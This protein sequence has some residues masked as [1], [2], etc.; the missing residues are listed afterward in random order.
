VQLNLIEH[1]VRNFVARGRYLN[2]SVEG[3]SARAAML[4]PTPTREDAATTLFDGLFLVGLNHHTAGLGLREQFFTEDGQEMQIDLAKLHLPE[5]AVLLTCNR[6]E[7]YGTGG[8]AE[9]IISYFARRCGMEAHLMRQHLYVVREQDAAMH[10][11]RVAAGLDS[12]VIGESQILGQVA[13]AAGNAQNAGAMLSRLFGAAILAGKRARSETAIG[14]HTL[15]IS[16]A[17]IMLAAQSGTIFQEAK[18]LVIGAGEMARQAVTALDGQGN[19]RIINRSFE[20]AQALAAESGAW[21]VPWSQ[22][23]EAL[24]TASVVIAA[25]S[26]PGLV[27]EAADLNRHGGP[28]TLIDLGMPRNIDPAARQKPGVKLFD[29]DDLQTVVERHRGYRQREVAAVEVLLRAE[30]ARLQEQLRAWKLGPVINQVRQKVQSLVDAEMQHLF[31]QI[32]PLNDEAQ[33]ALQLLSHRISAKLLH[34]PTVALRS[35][36]GPQIASALCE[37]FGIDMPAKSHPAPGDVH[38]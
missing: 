25:T 7:V 29:I 3:E 37:M 14:R 9:A 28:L 36:R 8:D 13:G 30:M 11:M 22:L 34:G 16:H 27:I 38:E 2:G 31:G 19:V 6:I 4:D 18:V 32:G 35:P 23:H 21:A 12:P 1:D 15:S 33:S 20:R 10:L 24:S 26:S 5:T 17:G